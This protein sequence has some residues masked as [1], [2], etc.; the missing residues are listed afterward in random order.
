MYLSHGLEG[1]AVEDI[2]ATDERELC[3]DVYFSSTQLFSSVPLWCLYCPYLTR[4]TLV[5]DLML[6][7]D[8]RRL[9]CVRTDGKSFYIKFI[10]SFLE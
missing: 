2:M 10:L 5:C 4:H 3:S 1:H 8:V 7:S 6:L 9:R